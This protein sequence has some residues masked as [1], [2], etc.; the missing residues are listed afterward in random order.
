MD[1]SILKDKFGIHTFML[2]YTKLTF[3]EYRRLLKLFMSSVSDRSDDYSYIKT[4]LL[5]DNGYYGIYPELYYKCDH[6][7]L[8][9]FVN[10][11]NLLESRF[12]TYE[13]MGSNMSVCIKRLISQIDEALK[14]IA[15]D[16]NIYAFE[17][18]YLTRVDL[19]VNYF[20]DKSYIIG[21]Y[22]QL[23][24]KSAHINRGRIRGLYIKG[25]YDE[26]GN[27]HHFGLVKSNFELTIYDKSF[28]LMRFGKI[29][30]FDD[31]Y[32]NV[33]RI[34]VK[35]S[36]RYIG[37]M[38]GDFDKVIP[39]NIDK[40]LYLLSQSQLI[41]IESLNKVFYPGDYLQ[42]NLLEEVIL[43]SSFQSHI[44][45]IMVKIISENDNIDRVYD[46]IAMDYDLP[47]KTIQRI[48][49]KFKELGINSTPIPMQGFEDSE[50]FLPSFANLM[51]CEDIEQDEKMQYTDTELDGKE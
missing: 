43:N 7:Y 39:S 21:Q 18:A 14:L 42:R 31:E 22:I 5:F 10:P 45:E 41:M 47:K 44:K 51:M 27:R 9:V 50:M 8:C 2:T 33:L 1:I 49:S 11:R 35:L 36:R 15:D 32:G 30:G 25:R 34:E 46:N 23:A 26:A 12:C 20:F 37:K 6:R 17:N 28:E 13:I 4:N 48:K 19:C 3:T 29:P 38:L 40:L 24:K 16:Y